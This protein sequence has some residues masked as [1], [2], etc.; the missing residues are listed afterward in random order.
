MDLPIKT[1][2]LLITEFN[3]SMAESV[4]I[5]SLD[6]DNRRFLPDEVF[7][8]AQEALKTMSALISYYSQTDKPL[9]YPLILHEGQQIGHVQAIPIDD[10][11]E[12]GYHVGQAFTGSGYATEAVKAFL[13][14]VMER[15]DI[16]NTYAVCH[17]DNIASRRV[18]EKCGFSLIYEGIGL[19]HEKQQPVC[20]YVYYKNG[21]ERSTQVCAVS[22]Q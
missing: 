21:Q 6:E 15:L 22:I 14:K 16:T 4:Y 9:V 3:E 18:L 7:E 1:E 5:N 17:A 20:R 2:R 11:W 12:I 13:P 10:E 19:L 8:S